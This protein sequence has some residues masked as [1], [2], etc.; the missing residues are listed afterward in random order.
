MSFEFLFTVDT[1]DSTKDLILSV[2]KIKDE[3]YYK[4]RVYENIELSGI[5]KKIKKFSKTSL[6]DIKDF[7]T[8][9]F[10]GCE[11]IK[12]HYYVYQLNSVDN[13]RYNPRHLSNA[14]ETFCITNDIE[15]I[16]YKYN[17][18]P[19]IVENHEYKLKRIQN[20]TD[21]PRSLTLLDIKNFVDLLFTFLRDIA[22]RK[23]KF[24]SIIES[25]GLEVAF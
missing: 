8:V 18:L 11:T 21:K 12:F 6:E 22:E 15:V 14:V 7:L 1:G 17:T 24:D 2:E 13:K 3:E 5:R 4:V 23:N 9:K 16:V 20:N 25:T 10:Y 19:N